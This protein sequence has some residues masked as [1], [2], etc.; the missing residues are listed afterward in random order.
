MS[1][2]ADWTNGVK[3]FGLTT[4]QMGRFSLVTGWAVHNVNAGGYVPENRGY[5]MIMLRKSA[6][7]AA[8]VAVLLSSATPLAAA[9]IGYPVMAK[10]DEGVVLEKASDYRRRYRRNRRLDVDAG[11]VIIGIGLI[12]AIAAIADSAD[13]KKRRDRDE[14]Q[15]DDRSNDRPA[16]ADD[17]LGTAVSLC[18]DAA[19]RSA[20]N[21][22]RVEEIRSVTRDGNGWRVEGDLNQDSFTCGASGGRVDFIQ[23]NDRQI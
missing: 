19:E 12:A 21:G 13:G 9:E 2:I 20:G 6:L 17:D 15:Y 11:D 5:I 10:A 16:Y 22:A 7:A 4:Y 14:P 23:L 8:G 1:I 18:S 3:T